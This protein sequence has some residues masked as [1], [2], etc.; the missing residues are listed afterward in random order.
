[1]STITKTLTTTA[2][3]GAVL[4]VAN[5]TLNEDGSID[6]DKRNST[7]ATTVSVTATAVIGTIINKHEMKKIHD[8]ATSSYI[9]SL[10]NEELAYMLEELNL[11][12]TAQEEIKDVKT[13]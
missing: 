7:L 9:D 6:R 8:K 5:S 10:S 11:M 1:M 4:G 3:S 13:I 2:W 12:E